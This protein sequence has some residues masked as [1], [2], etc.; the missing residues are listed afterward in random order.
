MKEQ[1]EPDQLQCALLR[2]HNGCLRFLKLDLAI[3]A[4]VAAVVS[5]FKLKTPAIFAVTYEYEFGVVFLVALIAYALLFELFLTSVTNSCVLD[6]AGQ[7]PRWP[8]YVYTI[9]Q[10]AYIVQV[11]AHLFFLAYVAGYLTGYSEGVVHS[12][13]AK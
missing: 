10:W 13:R 11:A 6:K 12:F 5:Y 2:W 3:V 1:S 8:E 7:N 4:A 9:S